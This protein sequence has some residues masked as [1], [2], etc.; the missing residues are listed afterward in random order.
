MTGK[1]MWHMSIFSLFNISSSKQAL[2][3]I[4]LIAVIT[5]VDSQFINL[6]Y[7]TNLGTP[8]KLHLLLFVSFVI[9]ASVINTMLLLYAKRLDI[10]AKTSRAL[11]FGF[12]YTATSAV[13]YAISMILFIMILEML[14]FQEYDKT[15]LLLVTYFS[16]LWA[17]FTL[18][19]LSLTFIQWFRY[20]R[21]VSILIYGVVFSVII[22]LILITIP[23]LTDQFRSQTQLIYPR[24]YSSLIAMVISPTR[25]IAFIYGLGNYVL[26]LMMVSSWILTVLLLRPYVQRI[27]KKSFWLIVTIPLLYQL[28][29]FIVRDA[30]L[31]SDPSLIEV[32]Y[33]KQFQFLFAIS[34]QVIGLLFATAFLMIGRK[35]K[36]KVMRDYLIISSIGISSLFSSMEPGLPFYA[37]YP[38]FGIVTVFFL[39]LSSYLLL[40]GMLGIAAYVSR[41][42]ELRREIH[43]GL[44]VDSDMLKT[45]GMA[46]TQREMERRTIPLVDKINLSDEMKYHMDP[47]EEDVKIMIAEVLKELQSK[48]PQ[49][50]QR[51]GN[52]GANEFPN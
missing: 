40:V 12:A 15:Y 28:F 41:D 3:L 19:I 22:F 26:P 33:S 21:S 16:H 14:I 10:Q 20:T 5:I 35:T 29:T 30:N 31:I 25:D 24:D 44:E 47:S 23:L 36:R 18:G 7:G 46:E 45:L 50:D 39:G 51:N 27:G 11:L 2:V 4:I 9:L 13:Q 32:I 43:K 6:F 49:S 38:P 37:A 52:R 34:Y 1:G 17:A 8:G 42:S 48:A